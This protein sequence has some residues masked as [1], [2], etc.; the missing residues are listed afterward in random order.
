QT[1]GLEENRVQSLNA[2]IAFMASFFVLATGAYFV[3]IGELPGLYL[4]MLVMVSL[5]A[6]ENVGPLAALPAYFEESRIAARRL[7]EVVGEEPDNSTGAMPEGPVD[8]RADR[9]SYSYPN[10]GRLTLDDISF[11]L[12]QGSK[13]AIVG[14]SGSGKSTLLQLLL[15][16]AEPQSGEIRF[17]TE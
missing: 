7:E 17:G 2:L 13:T 16:V 5:G 4:A 10:D 1:E 11:Q 15:K 14:P 12:P 3:S 9:I 6:F 8:I